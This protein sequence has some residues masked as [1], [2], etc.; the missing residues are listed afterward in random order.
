MHNH[1]EDI[2]KRIDEAPIWF[3]EFGVPRY[4]L[5]SPRRLGNIYAMEAALAEVS[6]QGCGR[7]FRVA[8]TEVFARKGLALSD[9]I[10]L[11]RVHYGDPPNIDCCAAGPTMN[12]VMREVLE[13]WYRDYEVASDWQRDPIFEGPVAE[14]PLD[15]LDTVAEVLA[16]IQAGAK[17]LLVMCTSRQ[18]RYH[19]AGRISGAML[20]KGRVL[21]SSHDTYGVIARRMLDS[22]VPDA[23]IG[24]YWE[25]KRKVVLSPFSHLR[26]TDVAAIETVAILAGPAPRNETQ[27][28][29]WSDTADRLATE[30]SDKVR[31]EFA[32]SHSCR[33]IA[34]PDQTVDAGRIKEN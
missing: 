1:Y 16:A 3:D 6:C 17:T 8:L 15:P 9:E 19:L 33:M 2:I 29:S 5:F 24:R 23:D 11:R 18:N 32:L 31:I 30:L 4:D 22:L 7:L 13:Y 10:R 12:S 25:D 14:P 28:R 20:S 34:N 21:V 27:Q 26:D